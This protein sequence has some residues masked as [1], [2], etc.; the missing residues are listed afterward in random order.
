MNI[1]S[2]KLIAVFSGFDLKLYEARGIK[3]TSTLEMPPLAFEKH[4]RHEKHEG[5]YRKSSGPASE[6]EPHT[7]PADIDH[8]NAA[9]IIVDYLEKVLGNPPDKY[10]ELIVIGEP[11]ILGYFRKHATPKIAHLI[12]KS[13]AKNLTHHDVHAVESAA[14][15][16]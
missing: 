15:D 6:F 14:F 2:P 11:K 5:L 9:R 13:V 1:K 12:T 3:I 8:L 7:S 10:R 16:S 4:T